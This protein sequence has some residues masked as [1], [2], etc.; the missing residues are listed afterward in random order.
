MHVRYC[1]LMKG[2]RISCAHVNITTAVRSGFP[3]IREE[4][5]LIPLVCAVDSG[6]DR[7][8][9]LNIISRKNIFMHNCKQRDVRLPDRI[10]YYLHR[11]LWIGFQVSR[12]SYGLTCWPDAV[13]EWCRS[14]QRA[15]WRYWHPF[16]LR[17]R[18]RWWSPPQ[19]LRGNMLDLTE[20]RIHEIRCIIN[21]EIP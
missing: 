5:T 17:W 12:A 20:H 3:S 7:T 2:S 21:E 6:K 19:R 15:W 4:Q 10:I 16:Q 11:W 14:R 13:W 18:L 9:V 8:I 1:S